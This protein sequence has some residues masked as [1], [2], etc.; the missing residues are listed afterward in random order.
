[1]KIGINGRFL[2]AKQTGVQRAAFNLVRT[3]VELDRLNEYV[4]FT[5]Y[6]QVDNPLWDYPNVQVVPSSLKEGESFRNHLWE[7]FTLPRLAQRHGVDILHSPANMAPMFYDGP[8]IV[9]IHDL[10]RL[11]LF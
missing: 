2:V 8:S 5:G 10:W 3:L 1:M 9:H 7:Q 11:E 6:S 4:L